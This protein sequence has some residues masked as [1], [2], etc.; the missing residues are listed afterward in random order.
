MRWSGNVA[1]VGV[2]E[3]HKQFRLRNLKGSTIFRNT[4][5][6]PKD[7]IK[8][9]LQARGH[10]DLNWIDLLQSREICWAVVYTVMKLRVL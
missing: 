1:L 4:R 10:E 8:I 2:N 9:D 5:N 7:N 3:V 6:R